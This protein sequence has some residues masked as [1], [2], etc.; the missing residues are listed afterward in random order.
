M[1]KY[2]RP[3]EPNKILK[4]NKWRQKQSNK[5]EKWSRLIKKIK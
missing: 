5:L 4:C 3:K 1:K 2:Y